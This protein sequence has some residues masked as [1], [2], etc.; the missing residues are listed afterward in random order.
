[1]AWSRSSKNSLFHLDS[2]GRVQQQTLHKRR[3]AQRRYMLRIPGRRY[4]VILRSLPV[5]SLA[6]PSDA[7]RITHPAPMPGPQWKIVTRGTTLL[8]SRPDPA[9]S[10]RRRNIPFRRALEWIQEVRWEPERQARQALG[11]PHLG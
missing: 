8:I 10:P 5:L 1:M 11:V 2:G 9:P 3:I 7:P 6:Y 4:S